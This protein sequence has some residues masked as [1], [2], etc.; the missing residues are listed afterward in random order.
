MQVEPYLSVVVPVYDE[1]DSLAM[2][3]RELGAVLDGLDRRSEMV[4]VDDGSGDGSAFELRRIALSDA[5]VRVLTLDRHRGQSSAL[6]A[7]FQAARGEVVATLDADLQNDPADLPGLLDLLERT[8]ADL[9]NGVRI[10]RRDPPLR[11]LAGR[12]ANALRNRLLRESVSDVGCSLRVMRRR[13]LQRLELRRGMHRFLPTLLRLE[14]AHVIERPVAHRPRRYGRSKYGILGRLRAVTIDVVGVRWLQS[15]H[16][17]Y[18]VSE[19][20]RPADAAAIAATATGNPG[21][22][23]RNDGTHA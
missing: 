14:G 10:D 4:F 22:L 9:V 1:V 8:R 21:T 5:R 20:R 13:C 6:D 23:V 17:G 16:E 3:H 11:R 7:G 12:V 2:L 18:R 15:R 19:W